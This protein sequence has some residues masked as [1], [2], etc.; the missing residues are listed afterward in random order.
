M[1][2]FAV[3]GISDVYILNKSGDKSLPYGIPA[4][5]ESRR[6]LSRPVELKMYD[7]RVYVLL[8]GKKEIAYI[9]LFQALKSL[10]PDLCPKSFMIDFEKAVMNA[11]K[12]EFPNTKISHVTFSYFVVIKKRMTVDT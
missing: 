12:N 10:K 7:H 2:V 1:V 6:I 9:K 11:I 3:F 8:P 4:E 5:I